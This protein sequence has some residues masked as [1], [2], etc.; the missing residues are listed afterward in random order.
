MKE[1][2]REWEQEGWIA[3]RAGGAFCLGLAEA[4]A[5]G[6][7]IF[8]AALIRV[9]LAMMW[10]TSMSP[11]RRDVLKWGVGAGGMAAAATLGL[12]ASAHAAD[13][14]FSWMARLPDNTYL[15]HL[16]I[17]GTHDSCCTDPSNGTK[18]AQTQNWG[19]TEQ[20]QRGIRFLDIRLNGL[21]GARNELGVYHGSWYQEKRFQDVLEDCR[22]YLREYRSETVIMRVKNEN[23]GGQALDPVEFRRRFNYYLDDLGYRSLVW[24]NP[25]WPH[26]GQVRGKVIVAADFENTWGILD[27]SGSKYFNTQDIWNTNNFAKIKAIVNH[28]D[29]AWR[30]QNADQMYVNFTSYSDN[31][32]PQVTTKI[33]LPDV[34]KY[35][36]DRRNERTHLGIVPMDYPDFYREVVSLLVD[37]NFI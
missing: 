12:P 16:T 33:I 25:S 27:W 24:T 22:R 4:D 2:R 35:L 5:G 8:F 3:G 21:Q 34:I 14:Y 28:F 32:W 6:F 20:L 9:H 15:P 30:N 7:R 10:R 37:K 29:D 18:W 31:M 11:T 26:L 19:V 17:P 36:K 1:H 23:E 13:Y